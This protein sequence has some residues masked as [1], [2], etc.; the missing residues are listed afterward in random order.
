[1]IRVCRKF[2]H[3]IIRYSN[4]DLFTVLT[5]EVSSCGTN[6]KTIYFNELIKK[7][8]GNKIL[9]RNSKILYK[10]KNVLV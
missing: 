9:I 3:V 4:E 7:M 5:T 8:P 1:M 6:E 10:I 2:A